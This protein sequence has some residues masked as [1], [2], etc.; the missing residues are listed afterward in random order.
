M[1]T[2]LSSQ[3]IGVP[4]HA[5]PAQT[6]L[7]VQASPSLQITAL[8][9]CVQPLPGSQPSVVHPLPSSQLIDVPPHTPLEH[10]SSVVQTLP[11]LQ[12]VPS[13]LFGFEQMPVP[14]SQVPASWH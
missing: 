9:A 5:P 2:V 14:G 11:S 3:L 6:S 4:A 12:D 10:E 13:A 7:S 8:L 1:Q